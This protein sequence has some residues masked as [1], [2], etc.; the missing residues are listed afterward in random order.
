MYDHSVED[1][2]NVDIL[3]Y[4]HIDFWM[5]LPKTFC[6]GVMLKIILMSHL[7]SCP[8]CLRT[9]GLLHQLYISHPSS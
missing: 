1:L 9:V 2:L 6:C 5:K 4:D 3:D 7:F 8:F